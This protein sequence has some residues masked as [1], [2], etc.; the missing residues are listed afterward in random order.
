MKTFY[1]FV[2]FCFV[3]GISTLIDFSVL[4]IGVYFL[5]ESYFMVNLSKIF[6]IILSMTWSFPMNKHFTFKS[7]EENLFKQFLKYL[8]VY[9]ITSLINFLIFSGIIF[10]IGTA[11]LPRTIAFIFATGMGLML[12]FLGSLLWTFKK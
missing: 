3:G 4:N 2:I 8:S 7:K 12:N 1:K 5:G 6:G 9:G 11:F 10:F